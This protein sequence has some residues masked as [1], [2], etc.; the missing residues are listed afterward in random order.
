MTS[1]NQIFSQVLNRIIPTNEELELIN[2]ITEKLIDL[3]RKKANKLNFNYTRIEP[4][5]STGI[6][7]T[8][9]K[10]DF[11][12]DLFIGLDYNQYKHK[13][14]GLSKSKL[15]KESKKDFLALCKNWILQSL[16]LDKFQ[17]P[18]LLYAEHP[19]VTVDYI[20]DNL[21][22]KIDI[23]LYF[24]LELEYINKYGPI[25]AVD[26]SPWHGS[27]VRDKLTSEQK[28]DVRLLKQFFK[29]CY[30]YGDK[31][32][33]GMVG[34]IGYSA[35]LLIFYFKD[36]INLL[37]NFDELDKKPLDYYNRNKEELAKIVHFQ[38]DYLI[39]IDPI[40]K[41]RNVASAI[42]ERAYKYCN[43]KISE[44]LKQPSL[45]FFEIKPIPEINLSIKEDPLLSNTYIIEL[46]N[47]EPKIHYTIN[48]DKLY[49]LGTSIKAN[50][51]KEFSH[52]DRFG[53]I[54][55]EM[56]F[57]DEKN[58]YSLAIY[59]EKPHISESYIR[60]GPPITDEQHV[61]NFKKKNP[62]YFE[63]DGYLWVETQR[64][65][66]HFYEFLKEFV[67]DK[68]SDNLKITNIS[69][70]YNTI[71]STGKKALYILRNIILPLDILDT[72]SLR[73]Y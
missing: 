68:I 39:I 40:D 34:F 12:I 20:I 11:D 30:S 43:Q 56:Y 14:N 66:N 18:R 27:F 62:G 59:C 55:Y 71:S 65:F 57:E 38:N 1:I 13:Y 46:E 73:D 54:L 16:T 50:G 17:N 70:A 21:R 37:K 32:A 44:F 60:K 9:L 7:Q 23:V 67:K 33:V 15:K 3:L 26:R 52:V 51:Q 10:N 29:A 8:Q 6:K 58:Q 49:S 4:Q 28:N 24:D 19:Y 42:S 69:N 31:S 72:V 45:E 41:N 47:T 25:T 36:L 5:G 61:I 48:R 63:K 35:E 53:K 64:E 2:G 22:V